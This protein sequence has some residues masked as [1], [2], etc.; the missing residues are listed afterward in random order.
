[1]DNEKKPT[2]EESLESRQQE[3]SRSDKPKKKLTREDLEPL[4]EAWL[5]DKETLGE[6]KLRHIIEAW[7]SGQHPSDQLKDWLC[8][9]FSELQDGI[10]PKKAFELEKSRGR[11]RLTFTESGFAYE[12]AS[13]VHKKKK[14]GTDHQ[15]ALLEVA[16]ERE[17]HERT[18]GR[19]YERFRELVE[20]HE[21]VQALVEIWQRERTEAPEAIEALFES[22]QIP[23]PFPRDNK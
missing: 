14:A 10:P 9:V 3:E 6:T 20:A 1:M 18:I 16:E 22:L 7:K 23:W 19:H 2:P 5:Q 8:G 17:R 15:T 21:A 11:K 12:N 4:R 13:R